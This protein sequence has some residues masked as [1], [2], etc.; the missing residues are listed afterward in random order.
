MAFKIDIIL[1]ALPAILTAAGNLAG[2]V[3]GAKKD[4]Q[5]LKTETR[6]D[7]IEDI[8]ES[9]AKMTSELTQQTQSLAEELRA[10]SDQ[11]QKAQNEISRF[12]WFS[13]AAS[14]IGLSGLL[15]SIFK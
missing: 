6:L 5:N 3:S 8:V 15:L 10:L 1:K 4:R 11:L 14:I 12:K 7:R 9:H 13:V 2:S